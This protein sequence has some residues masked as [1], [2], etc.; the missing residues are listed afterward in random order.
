MNDSRRRARAALA[1]SIAVLAAGSARADNDPLPNDQSQSDFGGVG[2]LQMPS[3]RMARE[4]EL[5][6]NLID[7]DE[8]RRYSVS[9]QA[10]P[11]LET[12][13]R[14]TDTRTRDY[15]PES[16]SG[17]QTHKDKGFDAKVRLLQEDSLWPEV[18]VGFRDI[19]GTGL[20]DGEFLAANKRI[21]PLDVTL[22]VGWGY[23][24]KGDNIR[25]VFCSV[26]DSFCDRRG[27]FAGGRQG[28]DINFKRFFHGESSLFGGLEYQTPWHPLRIK[29]EYDGNDYEGEFAGDVRQ[30]SHVNVGAT[31][32][33]ADFGD[34]HL[35]YQRGNTFS[36]GITLR[37]NFETVPALPKPAAPAYAPRPA[38]D[39]TSTDWDGLAGA[40]ETR[41]GWKDPEITAGDR[42]VAVRSE[43]S[44]YRDPEEARRRAATLLANVL[45]A[46]VTLFRLV[47]LR[48]GIPVREDAIERAAVEARER[49]PVLGQASTA[50][51]PTMREP[52]YRE[53]Q[54]FRTRAREQFDAYITPHVAQSLGGPESFYLYQVGV[55]GTVEASWDNWTASGVVYINA[56]DNYDKFNFTDQPAD[57]RQLPPVRTL[58]RKYV[59]DNSGRV[60]NLQLTR[61][62]SLGG[63]WYSQVYAGQ[64]EAMFGGVGAEVL[65]RPL[66]RNWA[67]GLDISRVRQRDFRNSWE[68]LDYKVTTGHLSAY[69]EVPY[70]PDVN[71]SISVGRYLAGDW[72]GTIDLSRTFRS[73]IRAGFFATKT[74]VSSSEYGE[75]SFSKGFYI[76]I[77]F[78]IVSVRPSRQRT[79]VAW[80][81][82]TRDGGQPLA[83]RYGLW[84]ITESRGER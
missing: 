65:Y 57:G 34:A 77:P 75:G 39:L 1:L 69:L 72:G 12:T 55:D 66:G 70:L 16:F 42:I 35:S 11:W 29:A 32:R 17:D 5:S 49:P 9:L 63:G 36:F 33:L 51:A 73:G 74:D 45:P 41:A 46:D 83:R 26:R 2:L 13:I 19:A 79:T 76:S 71:A 60:N 18:S 48:R 54:V 56:F 80:I 10:L 64:L 84:G 82:L 8:Y 67:I 62:D 61:F 44:M 7:N 24:A 4:G 3:A 38:A 25:N 15:G 6:L 50:D 59:R 78:D 21:G 40:L 81:P 23:L 47:E 68:F 37:T 20:F 14:Y 27:G 43:Q 31:I 30:R 53:A 28:G 22:G 52:L 58:V